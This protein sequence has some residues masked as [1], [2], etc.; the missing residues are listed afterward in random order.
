[1]EGMNGVAKLHSHD[2]TGSTL[3]RTAKNN[4]FY[5]IYALLKNLLH[6]EGMNEVAKLHSQK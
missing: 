4:V 2:A 6:M 3:L 5:N 1:M